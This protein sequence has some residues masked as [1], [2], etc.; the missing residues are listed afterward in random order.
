MIKSFFITEKDINNFL[1]R[2]PIFG[3]AYD[4]IIFPFYYFA[5]VTQA[6]LLNKTKKNIKDKFEYLFNKKNYQMVNFIY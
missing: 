6:P 2:I 1:G 5:N 3:L 4:F